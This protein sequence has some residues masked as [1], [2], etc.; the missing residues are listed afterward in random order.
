MVKCSDKP[1]QPRSPSPT[2]KEK[3]RP[4]KHGGKTIEIKKLWNIDAQG[5]IRLITCYFGYQRRARQQ[6]LEQT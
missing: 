4:P 5:M 2:T 6:Q 3:D 1:H